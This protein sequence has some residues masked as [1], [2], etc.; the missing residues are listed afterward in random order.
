MGKE[1]ILFEQGREVLRGTRQRICDFLGISPNGD[2]YRGAEHRGYVLILK[3]VT[4][5]EYLEM[6]RLEYLRRHLLAF[7]NTCLGTIVS[8]EEL[9]RL[10][11]KLKFEGIECTYRAI[12]DRY[13]DPML[14]KTKKQRKRG[15]YWWVIEK[16][17]KPSKDCSESTSPTRRGKKTSR[18]G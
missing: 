6:E 7:G 17:S 2:I 11:K 4:E 15:R 14:N 18:Q 8:E 1:Y 5:A 16:I 12:E 9:Q 3:K 13:E 10:L